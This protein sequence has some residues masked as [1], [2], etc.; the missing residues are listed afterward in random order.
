MLLHK[1]DM[2]DLYAQK[3]F[4]VNEGRA[5]IEE[6]EGY[7]SLYVN[8]DSSPL[9]YVRLRWNR[10]KNEIRHDSVKVLGDVWERC[11][12]DME[13]RGIKPERCMPWVTIISNGSDSCP[14]T[15]GRFTECFGVKVR[16]GALCF[17]MVDAAG[18]TLIADIRCGGEGVILGGRTLEACRIV[19]GE[20]RDVSAFDAADDF[21]GRLCDDPIF[22]KEPVYGSNNWY[23]AYG[24]SSHEEIMRD[25]RIV[26]E[27]CK[28]IPNRPYMVIDDGWQKND[29]D[30]PWNKG[31]GKFPDMSALTQYMRKLDIKPGIW[32]RYTNDTAGECGLSAECHLSRDSKY[33]DVS[34]P[35]VLEYV[36]KCTKRIV[37]EWGFELIKH[38]YST[39]DTFGKWASTTQCPTTLTDNGWH[40]HDRSK[41]SAE[42]IVNFY[43][44]IKEAAGSAVVLGCNVIG[45]LAAG[46]V[47]ANRSGDDTSG[48]E[49]ETT[50]RN[51]INTLAFHMPQN[52]NFFAADADCV[53]MTAKVPWKYNSLWLK[54]LSISG[55]PLFVSCTPGLPDDKQKAELHE[56][57]ARNAKQT[58]KLV[59]L[60]WMETTCPSRYL[61]NG[62]EIDF[63]WIPDEG[64]AMPKI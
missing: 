53:G 41:T 18:I 58:D 62:I 47:E 19:F 20:Y 17:W 24:N 5:W 57:F 31:N 50:R 40:F 11:Y 36:R 28:D 29:C 54:I 30:G 55:S 60:D 21:Y 15:K 61:L 43:R 23:Y 33:L 3:G 49:W 7:M 44:T 32:I 27:L 16:A 4:E 64:T 13:W 37:D 25:T 8:A 22:P 51:G 35:D 46:L 42:I 48:R 56:A 34:H 26:A 59:P 10:A 12:G 9:N 63:D 6:N 38:D 45:H 14:D 52:R 39:Y 1:P 2:I